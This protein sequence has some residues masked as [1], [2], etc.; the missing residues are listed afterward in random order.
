M[1]DL[2]QNGK[3]EILSQFFVSAPANLPAKRDSLVM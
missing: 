1:S 2:S 3:G